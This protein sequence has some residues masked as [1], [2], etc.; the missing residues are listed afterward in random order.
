MLYDMYQN[1]LLLAFLIVSLLHTTLYTDIVI[2]AKLCEVIYS[3]EVLKIKI[4]MK[5]CRMMTHQCNVWVN[6]FLKQALNGFHG[7]FYFSVIS[8]IAWAAC[9]VG[10]TIFDCKLLVLMGWI[11]GSLVAYNFLKYP[12]LDLVRDYLRRLPIQFIYL[13]ISG[14]IIKN[15]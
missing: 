4:H 14:V 5:W 2:W 3:S 9:C 6:I 11:W 13:N 1:F 8:K 15:K 12:W 7:S 10:K